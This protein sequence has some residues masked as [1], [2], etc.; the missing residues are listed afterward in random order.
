MKL[1]SNWVSIQ[2]EL[3][4][5]DV[6][7]AG[8]IEI[9]ARNKPPDINNGDKVV[10]RFGSGHPAKQR[11][12]AIVDRALEQAT[13]DEATW[14]HLR[15][16]NPSIVKQFQVRPQTVWDLRRSLYS[17]RGLLWSAIVAVGVI[18]GII[19]GAVQLWSW[20]FATPVIQGSAERPVLA[21][22]CPKL[23][24]DNGASGAVFV[25]LNAEATGSN[26]C[27]SQ[28]LSPAEPGEHIKFLVSYRNIS[29][30]IQH[31]VVVG[32]NLPPKMLLVP[33]TSTIWNASYPKGTPDVSNNVG[34]GG[35][36]IGTYAP[37][38]NAYVEFTLATPPAAD[39]ACGTTTFKTVGVVRPEHLDN[40]SNTAT[41]DVIRDC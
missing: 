33:Y 11:K 10:V 14:N 9:E 13:I 22:D 34:K 15:S 12:V 17:R 21:A 38:A 40:Y 39:L 31:Q 30:S 29:N 20:A 37:H 36:N 2:A 24:S 41:V 27:W 5:G 32:A 23:Y 8:D 18:I 16:R 35:L 7:Q 1:H 26:D 6:A 3:V 4:G 28:T 25:Q 19:V